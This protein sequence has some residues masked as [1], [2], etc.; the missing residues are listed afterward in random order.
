M[1]VAIVTSPEYLK[2]DFP[3][4][5][6]N[7]GRLRAI[8]AALDSPALGLREFL[9]PLAP[10]RATEAQI[11]AVHTADYIDALRKVMAEAPAY[12]DS[13]PTYVVPESY[14]VACLAAGGAIRAVDAVLDGEADTAFALIRPPGHHAPPDQ[15]MGFCLFNNVAIAARHALTR[16]GIER[17]LI[18]DFDVHHGNGTQDIFYLDPSVLFVSTHQS[19]LYP[20]TGAAE[21][22][23]EGAG[24]G[25]T[26][27]LP[28]PGLAGDR[29]FDQLAAEIIE[30][31]ADR[32]KPNLVLVSAGFDAH[33]LD[34]LAGLQVTLSGYERLTR[35]LMAIAARHCGG[36]LVLCLEGGYHLPALSGG[37]TT[38]VRTLMGE[39]N[40]PDA[41]GPA[42][43]PEPDIQALLTRFKTIHNL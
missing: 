5:P 27:N 4:H 1:S 29:A 15:P 20:Y 12:V 34:P 3:D 39:T 8:E 6:E 37:V 10:R 30:P 2:H 16:P 23:G 26:I 21:E 31:A 42:P 38:V 36:R 40:L 33:W 14:E 24:Q 41:L 11:G 25:F 17:V 19:P 32:F 35:G 22:T 43:R 9:V 18:V 13:A 7:A 28:L